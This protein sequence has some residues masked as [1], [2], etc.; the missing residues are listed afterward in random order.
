MFKRFVNP[1]LASISFTILLVFP[2]DSALAAVR[3]NPQTGLWEGNIC[4]SPYAWTYVPFQPIGTLCVIRLPN[5]AVIQGM[6]INQ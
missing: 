5:G 4:A 1:I 2:W 3:F 6:I